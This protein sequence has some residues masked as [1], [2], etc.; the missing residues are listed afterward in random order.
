MNTITS[1]PLTAFQWQIVLAFAAVYLIWGSTYLAIRVAIET[2]PPFLMAGCRFILAGLVFFAYG[3][4]SNNARVGRIS[5]SDLKRAALIGFLM[6]TIGNGG[7]TWAEQR[8]SSGL[9]AVLVAVMPLWIAIFQ[10]LG[11][12]SEKISWRTYPALGLGLAGVA[13]LTHSRLGG[14]G[15]HESEMAGVLSVLLS[16][17]CWALGSLHARRE[18]DCGRMIFLA[19]QMLCGGVFLVLFGSVGN[20]WNGIDPGSFSQRSVVAFLFLVIFGSI[21][22]FSAYNWLLNAVSPVV[23]STYA[24]VNP[25]VAVFLGWLFAAET[26]TWSMLLGAVAII[27]S[28]LWVNVVNTGNKSSAPKPPGPTA[29]S[30]PRRKELERSMRSFVETKM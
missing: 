21:V 28:V 8:I 23:V 1:I 25:V 26:L 17:F 19:L 13:F 11:P 27:G 24:Y 2:M 22:G 7:V 9:A 14:E 6:V 15:A 3:K 10:S 29:A 4:L 5:L 20:E 30:S 18:A 12:T 16:T